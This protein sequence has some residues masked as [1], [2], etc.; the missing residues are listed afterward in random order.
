MAK[1]TSTDVCIIGGGIVGLSTAYF[2]SLNKI[3]VTVLDPDSIGSHASGFA[4]GGLSPLGEAGQTADIIS[5]LAVAR[6]GMAI[7]SDFAQS[8]PELTNIEIQ[9]RFRSA[10]DLAFT[11][12]EAVEA[13]SQVK[14]RANEDGYSV[15]WIDPQEVH[16]L[17]P[18]VSEN[19]LGAVFTTG[20]ADVEPYRLMLALTTA[21]EKMGV[22]IIHT[23]AQGLNYKESSVKSVSTDRGEIYC[24]SAVLAMG[25]WSLNAS[26]WI[27]QDIPIT[28]L[29]GQILRMKSDEVNLNMSVGWRGNYA[30]TK[31]DGLLW[32]GT[33]EENTGF[34]D[35]TSAFG[36]DSVLTA[37]TQMI[38]GLDSA[39]L[40]HHTACLRPL[41]ADGKIILGDVPN[42]SHLFI[43]SGTG[44]KGILLGP[45]MGKLTSDLITN[46][47]IGI[48]LN[49]FSLSRF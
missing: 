6:L 17:V 2:L 35:S 1:I 25:P 13:K 34:D 38:N 21:C 29:K 30:C 44:R 7:H 37:L 5:E 10:L 11:D 36:R 24:D 31:P 48:D 20:V 42:I 23:R 14:W 49:P 27:K 19:I 40:V 22:D 46:Q 33:T 47:P 18:E 32:A 8:L 39:E 28:P 4:Y 12:T 15:Q 26:E 3:S 16:N 43:A 45:G 9:H 41:S